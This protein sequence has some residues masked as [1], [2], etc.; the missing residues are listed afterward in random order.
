MY[1]PRTISFLAAYL[2]RGSNA[3]FTRENHSNLVLNRELLAAGRLTSTH[4]PRR[5]LGSPPSFL[6][7]LSS[8]P[9]PLSPPPTSNPKSQI[10]NPKFPIP[11]SPFTWACQ[12]FILCSLNTEYRKLN[13][14]YHSAIRN[15]QSAFRNP[16]STL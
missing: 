4:Q 12:A 11:H 2:N 13:T 14:D 7:L 16:Q 1:F 3:C 6:F 5:P 9:R 8:S 15:L 10:R